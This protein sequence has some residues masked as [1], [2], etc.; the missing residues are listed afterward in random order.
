MD[1]TDADGEWSDEELL[2]SGSQTGVSDDQ[3]N[4]LLGNL[5]KKKRKKS[6]SGR[7]SGPTGSASC[8]NSHHN[9]HQHQNANGNNKNSNHIHRPSLG[10]II[11]NISSNSSVNPDNN[12]NNHG[13]SVYDR[14][15]LLSTSVE[16]AVISNLNASDIAS[17]SGTH[18]MMMSAPDPVCAILDK[19][20]AQIDAMD[21]KD[22]SVM[23][24]LANRER[25]SSRSAKFSSGQTKS[26]HPGTSG[27]GLTVS[28]DTGLGSLHDSELSD[29]DKTRPVSRSAEIFSEAN[30]TDG[31]TDDEREKARRLDSDIPSDL[32]SVAAQQIDIK[33]KEIMRKKKVPPDLPI[34]PNANRKSQSSSRGA[35]AAA[36]QLGSKLRSRSASRPSATMLSTGYGTDNESVRTEEFESKF[37]TLLVGGGQ[38]GVSDSDGGRSKSESS[39]R[40][41]QSVP[42][43]TSKVT[44][45]VPK[46]DVPGL[47]KEDEELLQKLVRV[48]NE[49]RS[50]SKESSAA[51]I[52]RP[53]SVSPTRLG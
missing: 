34:P 12:V 15:P 11:K 50:S 44:L 10:S 52:S 18:R 35:A 36:S 5:D 19:I 33:F 26:L 3:E 45:T 39:K 53:R 23:S 8:G 25:S 9:P 32:D 48:A 42:P 38:G 21:A 24:K 46:F 29:M 22:M 1:G 37:M 47:A 41:P 40:R 7:E 20:D 2:R 51:T 13:L 14:Q 17:N 4:G 28:A 16:P 43:D 27:S 30:L 31:V 6:S 49:T